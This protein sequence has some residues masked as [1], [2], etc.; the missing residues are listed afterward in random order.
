MRLNG[1]GGGIC[2]ISMA[3]LSL[4]DCTFVGNIGGVGGGVYN[5]PEYGSA[6][7][8]RGCLFQNNHAVNG[9]YGHGGGLNHSRG[10]LDISSC[11]FVT[12]SATGSGGGMS[13]FAS[14]GIL[15]TQLHFH[16]QQRTGWRRT[17]Y[18]WHR[19]MHYHLL[20]F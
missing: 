4:V 12:N 17:R 18:R 6:H 9:N 15:L 8:V 3:R 16:R 20:Y 14:N 19:W 10:F 5:Q 2:S 13:E 7:E 11:D 1:F